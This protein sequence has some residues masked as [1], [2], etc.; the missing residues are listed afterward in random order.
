M[1]S[2]EDYERLQELQKTEPQTYDL[3]NRMVQS[4]LETVSHGCHDIRNQ[5]ALVSSYG[6]LYE[7]EHPEAMQS[8]Y[9]NKLQQN[10]KKTIEL[11]ECIAKYRYS[12]RKSESTDSFQIHSLLQK[13]VD[14]CKT[15]EYE[16]IFVNIT[17][18]EDVVICGMEE[19]SIQIALEEVVKNAFEACALKVFDI[20]SVPCV[21]ILVTTEQ[22]TLSVIVQ[23]NAGGF[24]DEILPVALVPFKTEKK[25]HYGLGLSTAFENVR[26]YGG[27]IEL[28]NTLHGAKVTITLPIEC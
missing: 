24:S 12:F 27:S 21:D 7:K 17:A 28:E 16:N 4:T 10:T 5:V 6:Q 25:A 9:Y 20:G 1:L 18:K 26:K 11:L 23:D 19:T 15:A 2:R 14:S 22:Q 13:V 3:I 8:T